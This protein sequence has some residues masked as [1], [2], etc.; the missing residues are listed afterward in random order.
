MKGQIVKIISNNVGER[1]IALYIEGGVINKNGSLNNAYFMVVSDK[2]NVIPFDKSDTQIIMN[3]ARERLVF[4]PTRERMKQIMSSNNFAVTLTVIAHAENKFKFWLVFQDRD[5]S[6]GW[7]NYNGKLWNQS[8][9]YYD[10]SGTTKTNNYAREMGVG[11][12]FRFVLIYDGSDY[13]GQ[14]L[15]YHDS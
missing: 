12:V 15:E 13:W 10:E 1:N 5:T 4:L 7:R 9:T 2:N 11:D 6:T 14:L 8:V 3:I